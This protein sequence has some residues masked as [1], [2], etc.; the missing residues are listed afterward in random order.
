MNELEQM[1]KKKRSEFLEKNDKEEDSICV[2][3]RH[4]NDQYLYHEIINLPDYHPKTIDDI[5]IFE[6]EIL[7][8]EPDSEKER[9]RF[10]LV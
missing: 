5:G 1:I 6:A 10:R 4:Q 3:K 8:I 7:F 9:D 2:V